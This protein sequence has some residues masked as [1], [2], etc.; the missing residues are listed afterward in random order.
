MAIS[1]DSI[2]LR[3]RTRSCHIQS[4]I[5]TMSMAILAMQGATRPRLSA[6]LG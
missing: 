4:A 5:I 1:K 2:D 6:F 3:I